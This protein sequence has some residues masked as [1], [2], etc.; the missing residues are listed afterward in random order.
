MSEIQYASQDL[1]ADF[2]DEEQIFVAPSLEN[3]QTIPIP[4]VE[5]EREKKK[6]RKDKKKVKKKGKSEKSGSPNIGNS[7]DERTT[8]KQ[9]SSTDGK[10][11][12]NQPSVSSTSSSKRIIEIPRYGSDLSQS[13]YS[14]HDQGTATTLLMFAIASVGCI[15]FALF[16]PTLSSYVRTELGASTLYYAGIAVAFQVGQLV[17]TPVFAL[18]TD[19]RTI[20]EVYL[21]NFFSFA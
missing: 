10:T 19:R 9:G 4:E 7:Y 8:K 21:F 6:K 2:D 17:A 3:R 14:H 12:E 1:F 20:K 11:K 13:Q 16:L 18:W 15:D 5:E